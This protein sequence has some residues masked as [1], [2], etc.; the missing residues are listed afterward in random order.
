MD[1]ANV[2]SIL[3]QKAKEAGFDDEEK[4]KILVEIEN[5]K[6]ELESARLYFE[7]VKDPGLI[8]YAI[9]KEAAAN[10]RY[11]YLLSLA[12]KKNIRN[13]EIKMVNC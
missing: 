7:T 6:Q 1:K 4:K 11:C 12:R 2:L 8:E 10:S 9:Y 5:A 3:E 13:H